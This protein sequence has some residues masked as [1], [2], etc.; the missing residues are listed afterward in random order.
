MVSCNLL[1]C[2]TQTV[3]RCHTA[4]FGALWTWINHWLKL[5]PWHTFRHI[6]P[7]LFYSAPGR[8]LLKA[9]LKNS[10]IF[11]DWNLVTHGSPGLRRC[12]IGWKL[13][14]TMTRMAKNGQ[15]DLCKHHEMPSI[16]KHHVTIIQ[17]L[18]TPFNCSFHTQAPCLWFFGIR[19][20]QNTS[21]NPG[22]YKM[23]SS[24]FYLK[25]WGQFISYSL[26]LQHTV[27]FGQPLQTKRQNWSDRYGCDQCKIDPHQ[28]LD[29][30]KQLSTFNKRG[31]T[32]NMEKK[33][34]PWFGC[35]EC[36]F[37]QVLTCPLCL[38]PPNTWALKPTSCISTMA[39]GIE[40]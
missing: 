9:A 11:C 40:S 28:D 31:K 6:I 17:S 18:P 19:W 27:A 2:K 8:K 3:F 23:G 20:P 37:P 32:K 29:G 16:I 21:T 36:N 38:W 4:L 1:S 5:S 34:T 24:Q 26:I 13:P 35:L 12:S 7:E 25:C 14:V 30:L 10:G 33:K 22:K 15:A 39:G